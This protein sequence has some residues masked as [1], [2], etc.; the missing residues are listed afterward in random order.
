MPPLL[1]A[2][3]RGLA[4]VIDLL[5]RKGADCANTSTSAQNAFHVVLENGAARAAH[6]G[7]EGTQ[8]YVR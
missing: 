5:R 6:S 2:A 3:S 8:R 7:A 4:S 1:L